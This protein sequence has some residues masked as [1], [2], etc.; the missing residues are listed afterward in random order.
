MKYK[1][2]L[3]ATAVA[4]IGILSCSRETVESE[5]P[6]STEV[7]L[8]FTASWA[9]EENT[10]TALQADGT[11]IWW[12]SGE[13]INVFFGTG[14]SGKFV[15]ENTEPQPVV[16][17]HG[18]LSTIVGGMETGGDKPAYWA[19][20]PYNASNT[21][22]GESVTLS[23]PSNQMASGG[24]FAD[25]FFPAVATGETYSLAFY[26]VCGGARFSVAQEG[27]TKVVFESNDGS[28]M[29][30]KV[31]VGFG[32]DGKPVVLD[33]TDGE[34]S[35]VVNAPAGGFVPGVNYFASMLPQAHNSGITVTL[36][37]ATKKATK[38]ISSPIT[39]KRSVFGKLDNVDAGLSSWEAYDQETE[40]GGTRSGLY[41]GIIGF[42]DQL[43]TMPITRLDDTSLNGFTSFIDAL[44][45]RAATLL[46][47]SVGE[48]VSALSRAR[49]PENLF[50]VSLVTFTDGLDQGSAM[51][52]DDYPG[53]EEYLE[54]LNTRLTHTTV[55]G[56]PLTA[57][58]I[59]L[60]GS[61]VTDVS[62]FRTNLQKLATSSSNAFE[63]SD[64]STVNSRFQ[65][66]ADQ[67]S[68]TQK[69]YSYDL[70]LTIAGQANGT[71]MRF[72]FDNV[73]SATASSRYIEGVF[74]LSSRSLQEVTYYGMTSA[75]G[76]TVKGE[77][78]GIYVSFPFK[79]VVI[80]DGKSDV[81]NKNYI[82]H[83]TY[84]TASSSW[85]INSEFD[86]ENDAS[87]TTTTT[88]KSAVVLLNLDCSTSLGSQFSTL[89]SHAKSFVQ[90]LYNASY[91][92]LEVSGV[93]L[94]K[95]ELTLYEGKSTTLT[96][97]VT[98][99]TA[100]NK[101]VTWSSSNPSVATVD[102]T[103]KVTG[104][105]EGSAVITATTVD[106]GY[107]ASCEV[108]VVEAPK[109]EAI[110]LGL[111]VKW[112]SFNLGAS[113][114]EEYGDYYAWGEIES[115]SNYIWSTYKWCNG[116]YNNLTKYNTSSSNGTVDNKTVLDPEDDVAQVT[117][118]GNWRM[119]ED[120]E[121]TELKTQCTWT[122]TSQNGVYGRKVTGPNGN[123]IF[124]PAAGYRYG[125]DLYDAGSSGNY[126][127]SSVAI[128]D[129]DIP[130]GAWDVDFDS[131]NVYR[132]YGSYRCDGF[133]VRPVEPIAV[134]CVLLNKTE[135]TLY[136]GKS[137][138]LTATVTPSTAAN[139]SVIW[140]SN[141]PSVATVDQSGKVTGVKEGSA[142]ITA[143]T[144]DG[145]YTASCAVSVVEVPEFEAVDLGLGVR[146]ASFNLGA[147]APEEYGDYY[148][149]GLTE[150]KS[151]YS[152]S[153]YK[154]CNGSYDS[155]TK[156]N[157]SSSY[158]TVDYKTVLDPEDDVAH[159]VLGG[160]W[161]M[162]TDAEWTE[163]RTQCTWTWTTQNGVNGRK[164]TGPN[165]NSVF[166]PAAGFRFVTDLYSAGSDGF[167]WSSSLNTD[168]P[169]CARYVGFNSD[170]VST[171][172]ADRCCGRSVRPVSE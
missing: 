109:F 123:S 143:T 38:T 112:A 124:L 138:T 64:M 100:A 16:S 158:G 66:I 18:T 91:D 159:V 148:A 57:Y 21:C 172:Y 156:Y 87:V 23:L 155:L 79:G 26:N 165:G 58:S 88:K 94:N 141:N 11:S 43:Y 56:V 41:L 48:S 9:G 35:V 161:R 28:P 169:V 108:I 39:V 136:E 3:Y 144:V 14:A 130:Y 78:S 19:V 84:K 22:D 71:R 5:I 132:W 129:S 137:T 93:S 59:G 15:S 133:S 80:G 134:P 89:K 42:N 72:T 24:S 68:Q 34:S 76:E 46:Y 114:P 97:T 171:G 50:N 32:E 135:L 162:P 85:Q 75:S 104:V 166:L 6:E 98:P 170:Y 151:N 27:I 63:V 154:W 86:A 152:W 142:V 103:G 60:R 29:A 163:L 83:W 44:T 47:Y 25:H 146:W 55:S 31:R 119:P 12:T 40:G 131:D 105:K 49:Y 92:P 160:N 164:V 82:R 10:R 33:I 61:D 65:E 153:T 145:G 115:K 45:T 101:S 1:A 54:T 30:G 122:W 121:W 102:Q 20:Y 149:W 140:A 52:I 127:S 150:T 111:S 69:I 7:E 90:R 167:Y 51:M 139:K 125:T 147:S 126:W 118:G 128:V 116:D 81:L 168:Y 67:V 120:A 113:A 70:A 8:E 2:L 157:T 17:F 110:D 117:L 99:S 107:Q 77:V 13:E 53:D 73:S 74:N 62:M 37:T 36:Y 96:A 95:T 106:G 4:L